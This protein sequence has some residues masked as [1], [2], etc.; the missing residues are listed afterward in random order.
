MCVFIFMPEVADLTIYVD[1]VSW[2]FNNF[3]QI[4]R[5]CIL[6]CTVI[7]IYINITVIYSELCNIHSESVSAHSCTCS[8]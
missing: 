5:H 3:V 1:C 2:L 6:L 7:I 4:M 8:S